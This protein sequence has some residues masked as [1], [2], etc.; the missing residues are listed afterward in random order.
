M[1]YI[2]AFLSECDKR[3]LFWFQFVIGL[4][5]LEYR[6][7]TYVNRK[8]GDIVSIYLPKLWVDSSVINFVN[9]LK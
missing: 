4:S 2:S 5:K 1:I 7:A 9:S 3:A 6:R 8:L